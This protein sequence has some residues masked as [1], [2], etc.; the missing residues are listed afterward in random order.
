[1][2]LSNT[3]AFQRSVIG[4]S[5][6]VAPLVFIA[7]ELLHAHFETEPSA[8]LD[9]IA[10][11]PDRWYGAHMLVLLGLA[12]MLPAI[13][14]VALIV[15]SSD[16][17]L[18]TGSVSLAILG[19][20]AL[21]ALVGMELVAWQ[22]AQSEIARAEMIAL[23]ENTAENEAIFPLVIVALLLPVGWL[24]VGVGLYRGRAVSRWSA[25][26]IGLAQLVGFAS[27]LAGATKWIA[28]TAQ[29]AFAVGLIP[30]GLRVLHAAESGS[31]GPTAQTREVAASR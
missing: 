10:A 7:A 2:G 12:L 4:A 18:G 16:P 15:R 13:V 11:N 27:E 25:V 9:A 22:L 6:I 29:V 28:V 14:G 3:T 1:M 24:L 30:I 19:T 5:M 20:V 23:W 26:L 17:R 21:A 31:T 8:Y